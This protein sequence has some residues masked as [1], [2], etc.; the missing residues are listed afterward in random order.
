[1]IK[2]CHKQYIFV[3]RIQR[4]LGVSMGDVSCKIVDQ[5]GMAEVMASASSTKRVV[6]LS[7]RSFQAK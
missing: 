6:K 5:E 7:A 4:S 1:M 2:K 3:D